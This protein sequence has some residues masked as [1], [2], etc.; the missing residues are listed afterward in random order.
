MV[1][2]YY[3]C[4]SA[5]TGVLVLLD[6]KNSKSPLAIRVPLVYTIPRHGWHG[7]F[8]CVYIILVALGTGWGQAER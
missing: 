3:I 5:K 6:Y 8:G 1:A 4:Q 7:A 2:D